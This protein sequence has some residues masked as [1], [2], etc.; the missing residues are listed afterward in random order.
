MRFSISVK[1][2][3]ACVVVVGGLGA[4]LTPAASAAYDGSWS[5]T[6]WRQGPYNPAPDVTRPDV[7]GDC[8]GTNGGVRPSSCVFKP[9]RSNYY[10]GAWKRASDKFDNC[11]SRV[12]AK[13][14]AATAV[15]TEISVEVGS[16]TSYSGSGGVSKGAFSAALEMSVSYTNSQAT[17]NAKTFYDSQYITVPPGHVGWMEFRPFKVDVMGWFDV[18]YR[19]RIFNHYNWYYPGYGSAGVKFTHN[20]VLSSGLPRGEYRPVVQRCGGHR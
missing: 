2:L 8:R 12:A 20:T 13:F 16:T 5:S 7:I 17:A 9:V 19:N 4:M 18:K 15:S 11:K 3:L 1:R 10:W 6:F 14:G